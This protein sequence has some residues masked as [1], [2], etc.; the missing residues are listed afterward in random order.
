MVYCAVKGGREDEMIKWGSGADRWG[1]ERLL[2]TTLDG[3]A[4]VFQEESRAA[5]ELVE[6]LYQEQIY[7]LG[8]QEN[9]DLLTGKALGNGEKK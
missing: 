2:G 8:V 1:R 4:D 6:R 9:A 5:F 7:K 3:E